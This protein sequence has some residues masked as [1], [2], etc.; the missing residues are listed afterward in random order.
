MGILTSVS[1]FPTFYGISGFEEFSKIFK[2]GFRGCLPENP[3]FLSETIPPGIAA[4]VI[5][6]FKFVLCL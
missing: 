1:D 3:D 5:Y 2:F 6:I 4:A